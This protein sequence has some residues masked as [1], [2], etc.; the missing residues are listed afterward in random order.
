MWV[1]AS[2]SLLAGINMQVEPAASIFKVEQEKTSRHRPQYSSFNSNAKNLK[3][4][5]EFEGQASAKL[6]EHAHF[7]Q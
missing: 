4:H 2:C 7:V 3:S 6:T 1:G 5:V